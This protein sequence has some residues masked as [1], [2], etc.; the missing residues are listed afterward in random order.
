MDHALLRTLMPALVAGHLP[1]NVRSFHYRIC[2]GVPQV[3]SLGIRIDPRPF[4]GTVIAKTQEALIIKTGRASFAAA[5][6]ALLSDDPAEGARIE[7]VPYARRRFDGQRVDA[8]EQT[9]EQMANSQTYTL[10][11]VVLGSATVS[12]PLPKARCPELADLIQQLEQMPAPDGFRRIVHLLVDAGAHDFSTVDPAPEH[13][14]DT[15]PAISF[16]VRTTRFTSQVIILYD[17][18]MDLFVVELR[19]GGALVDRVDLVDFSS[20]SETLE[21]LIDDGHWRRIQI[22]ILTRTR[23]SPPN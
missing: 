1:R 12:L 23:R 21:R 7:V 15:P 11:T 13:I 20:L 2:D 17:R 16:N 3:S 8:A 14:V 19:R 22:N 18:S 10:S 9:T 5:A 4:Q 6:R